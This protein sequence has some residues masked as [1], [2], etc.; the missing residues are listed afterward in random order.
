MAIPNQMLHIKALKQQY[1]RLCEK[2]TWNWACMK[3]LILPFQFVKFNILI[4]YG[5]IDYWSTITFHLIA[6]FVAFL[7]LDALFGIQH[8]QIFCIIDYVMRYH[9]NVVQE[10]QR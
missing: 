1:I 10:T 2:I 7:S 5:R 4:E 3:R 8:T 6:Y 9:S